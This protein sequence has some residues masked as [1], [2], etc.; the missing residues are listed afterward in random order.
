MSNVDILSLSALFISLSNE[1]KN[2]Q[3]VRS[4]DQLYNTATKNTSIVFVKYTF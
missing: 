2:V 4:Q 1:I 3:N